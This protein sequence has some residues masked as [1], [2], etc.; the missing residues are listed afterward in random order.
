MN[1]RTWMAVLP[2]LAC[3]ASAWAQHC[4]P[5]VKEGV[6]TCGNDQMA[7]PDEPM[8]GL[9]A[10]THPVSTKNPLAQKFFDQGLTLHYAFNNEQ[11]ILFFR[12][13]AELD[14]DLAMAYWGIALAAS[15]NINVTIDSHCEDVATGNIQL[16][17]KKAQRV[18]TS[19][20]DRDLIDA[21]SK[22]YPSGGAEDDFQLSVDY[23]LAMEGVY[24]KYPGDPDVATLYADARMNLQ[25]WRLWEACEPVLGTQKIVGALKSVLSQPKTANHLGANHFYIHAVEGSCRPEQ[26]ERSAELLRKAKLF[27]A[28]HLVHMPSHIAM[29][30]GRFELAAADNRDAVDADLKTYGRACD[31]HDMKKCLPLYVGH[32]LGHNLYFELAANQQL[33]RLEKSLQLA[34]ET[35]KRTRSYVDNEPGLEHYMVS[36]LITRARFR[37]WDK[38][39]EMPS[40][41]PKLMMAQTLWQWAKAMAL[42]ATPGNLPKVPVQ[43]QLYQDAFAKVPSTLSWGNN[44]AIAY[45][46]LMSY[47]LAA[48]VAEHSGGRAAAIELLKLAVNEEDHLIYDEPNAWPLTARETLGGAYLRDGQF[49]EAQQVFEVDLKHNAGSPRSLFGRWKSLAGQCTPGGAPRA[50]GPARGA[51]AKNSCQPDEVKKAERA[52]REAWRLAD[53]EL[54]VDTL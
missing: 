52:F 34:A 2:L 26:A 29:R 32:Y 36:E 28:G 46:P 8:Q 17:Q 9:G 10:L 12:K 41:E 33:G 43:R 49:L 5:K 14:P 21:L 13:A 35:E 15:T 20:S 30:T 7:L 31:E 53:V 54:T 4:Q 44:K 19:E 1:L 16:A 47:L 3:P 45:Q 40:P 18:G 51:S 42:A 38:V 22:R 11:S 24:K 39:L 50:K 23:A 37:Q 48:Q 6:S 25:P 27:S